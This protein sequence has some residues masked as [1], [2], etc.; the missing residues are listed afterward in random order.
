MTPDAKNKIVAAFD[1]RRAA[2]VNG[3]ANQIT[4]EVSVNADTGADSQPLLSGDHDD[5]IQ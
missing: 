3:G 1:Q 2:R 5:E 4:E